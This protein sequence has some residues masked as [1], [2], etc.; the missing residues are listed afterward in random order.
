MSLYGAERSG[1]RLRRMA[2]GNPVS[3]SE[4][5]WLD[6]MEALGP[7][8]VAA[9]LQGP[10]SNYGRGSEV[11]GIVDSDPHPS[12]GFVEDWLAGWHRE[13]AAI[14]RSRFRWVVWLAVAAAL[15]SA[16]AAW[17]VIRPWLD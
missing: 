7:Q 16:I 14:E 17:P 4:K 8:V 13:A 9:K 2:D 12:R 3:S 10:G 5:R 6:A 11:R 1:Y 15:F